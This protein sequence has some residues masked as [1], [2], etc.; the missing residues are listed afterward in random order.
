MSRLLAIGDIHGQSAAFSA[1]LNVIKPA[2]EDVLVLLGDFIN[3]GPDSRGVIERILG[4]REETQLICLRGNHEQM[5]LDALRSA[6]DGAFWLQCGGDE[7]LRSFGCADVESMPKHVFDFLNDTRLYHETEK[8]IFVHANVDSEVPMECQS[9]ST[10]LWR[11]LEYAPTHCSGKIIICGH[12]PQPAGLPVHLGSAVCIDTDVGK[13]GWLTCY[14][15]L[16][17]R[18]WQCH[19]S[20]KRRADILLPEQD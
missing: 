1:L 18:F 4:L 6:E 20:G 11:H 3:R 14:E 8:F 19:A 5:L 17:N 2:R 12:T 15:P 13:S 7:T 16:K 9:T 10:L